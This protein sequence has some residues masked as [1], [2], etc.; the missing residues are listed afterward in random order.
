MHL[1]LTLLT[2][3]DA[4][5]V[6][7][8]S[9]D[10]N[11]Y[12]EYDTQSLRIEHQGFLGVDVGLGALAY[13]RYHERL[14]FFDD[15]SLGLWEIDRAT[16]A[17]SY[18]GY[19]GLSVSAAAFT[20]E[21]ILAAGTAQGWY[22]VDPWT[23]HA[24]FLEDFG[25]IPNGGAWYPELEAIVYNRLGSTDFYAYNPFFGTHVPLG[26]TQELVNNAGMAWVPNLN[27][28]LM[29]TYSGTLWNVSPT[30]GY[31]AFPSTWP[32]VSGSVGATLVEGFGGELWLSRTAGACGASE[33]FRLDHSGLNSTVAFAGG[34]RW[35]Q[36]T[37]PSGPCAGTIIPLGSPTLLHMAGAAGDGVTEWTVDVPS[38]ACGKGLVAI[39][40]FTC[41]VSNVA[42]P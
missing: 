42:V 10:P 13:D 7:I 2:P 32:G 36:Y 27:V 18:V 31:T 29:F 38:R 35:R 41:K 23:G 28:F 26:G 20:K 21:G 12:A 1:L 17:A 4:A 30:S 34:E 22:E 9:T 40:L 33:S 37:I 8:V 6:A 19:P 24:T 5:R 15:R 3:A 11:I 14:L 39:D 16:G 25:I